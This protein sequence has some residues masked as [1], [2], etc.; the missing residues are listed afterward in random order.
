MVEIGD[1]ILITVEAEVV[2][3]GTG[4]GICYQ[5]MLPQED[6]VEPRTLWLNPEEIEETK[7]DF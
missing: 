3:I 2:N 6:F 4:H 5:V 7:T 1:K